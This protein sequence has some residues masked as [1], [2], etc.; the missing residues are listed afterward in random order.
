MVI[1]KKVYSFLAHFYCFVVSAGFSSIA[2]LS[3]I[4][5]Q[6]CGKLVPFLEI[7]PTFASKAPELSGNEVLWIVEICE[8]S[9]CLLRQELF[10]CLRFA[11]NILAN[12]R[13][14]SFVLHNH[15]KMNGF[16]ESHI[17]E[18]V[19]DVVLHK[20]RRGQYMHPVTKKAGDTTATGLKN[21]RLADYSIIQPQSREL[22][23]PHLG[24]IGGF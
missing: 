23:Q 5:L 9:S 24:P 4:P 6:R 21:Y 11:A 22:Q 7:L 3:S 1:S 14:V 13:I 18:A 8:E 16:S 12:S 2:V 17:F 19:P 20:I 15:N 10:V